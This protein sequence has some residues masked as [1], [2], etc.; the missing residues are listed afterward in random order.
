MSQANDFHLKQQRDDLRRQLADRLG[1]L[2]A[3]EYVSRPNIG[4]TS[5][6]TGSRP[7]SDLMTSASSQSG[8]GCKDQQGEEGKRK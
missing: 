4:G 1:Q 5:A 7:G 2:V 8:A 6:G 3:R